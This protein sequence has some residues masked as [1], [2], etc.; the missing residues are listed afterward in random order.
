MKRRLLL[1]AGLALP[2]AAS[3]ASFPGLLN[4]QQGAPSGMDIHQKRGKEPGQDTG[5]NAGRSY[6]QPSADKPLNLPLDHGPHPDFRTEWWYFTG[7]FESPEL[8]EPLGLQITFFRSA[9]NIDLRNP[10]VFKP[11]QL[12]FAHAAVAMPGQGK[13]K[14][15]QV[16]R[17]AGSSG[18]QLTSQPDK[19][20]NIQMP[21]WQLETSNGDAW[22]CNIQT[23]QLAMKLDM[24]QTQQPWLQGK[25]G[26]SQKGPLPQQSSHYITLPHMKSR[27]QVRVAGKTLPV[28]GTFWMDHEWSSTVLADNAQGWDWVGLHGN[29]GE[30]LMAFQIRNREPGKPPVW[31][32][33]ALRFANG[34]V[35]NFSKVEFETLRQ[36][37][38]GRTGISY[39][40]AQMLKLDGQT[41][42]LEP[43]FDDQELDARASTGTL[44]WEGAV[45]VKSASGAPWGRGYLEMTGYDRPMQL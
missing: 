41:Y 5:G 35:Q 29:N 20:L 39:P 2:A 43:L 18:N 33:A 7:W 21:G 36:W 27:G 19:V 40:V 11:A 6:A 15:E 22:A 34:Q 12:L 13:L 28:S 23:P 17:R 42:Q 37:K 4:A 14:H 38:S 10:S 24:Q 31:T 45:R 3:L 30:A 1:K 32:H 9:P 26:F 25:Q 44:Y 8:K 16:I